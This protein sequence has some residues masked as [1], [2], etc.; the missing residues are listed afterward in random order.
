MKHDSPELLD[1][2]RTLDLSKG[3]R[4]SLSC[5]SAL[6]PEIKLLKNLTYLDLSNT[7]IE[8][9]PEGFNPLHL[10]KLFSEYSKLRALPEGFNPPRLE[11]LHL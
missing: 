1:E 6:P 2:I 5:I 11:V 3:Y 8:T 4:G 10:E 7:A 9:L